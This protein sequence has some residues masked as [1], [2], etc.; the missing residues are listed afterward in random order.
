MNDAPGDRIYGKVLEK[1]ELT[2]AQVHVS[3]N[4]EVTVGACVGRV[5]GDNKPIGRRGGAGLAEES[6]RLDEH[7]VVGARL[8]CLVAVVLVNVVVDVLHLG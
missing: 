8:D 5:L 4:L 1:F 3:I 6:V 2:L 7:L